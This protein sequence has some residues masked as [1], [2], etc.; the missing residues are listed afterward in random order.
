MSKV[1]IVPKGKT[2]LITKGKN[3][4]P[5]NPDVDLVLEENITISL[6]SSFAPL[7]APPATNLIT[8]AGKAI[9]DWTNGRVN[10][11]GQWKHLSY[12]TWQ[13][14][15]PISFNATI[16]LY[17]GAAGLNDGKTEVYDPAI[18]LC[19]LVLPT[20]GLGGNL[21][22]PGPSLNE[23]IG[24]LVT[25]STIAIEIGRVLRISHGIILKA[26]PQF[27]NETDS[28]G[29]PIWA[30]VNLDIN[31]IFSATVEALNEINTP[32]P[33]ELKPADLARGRG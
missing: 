33:Q 26:E 13:G 19:N 25:A 27:S 24:Q 22:A 31:S 28:N 7:V 8:E 11:S 2:L 16:G 29:Y 10:F 21:Q 23:V 4:V 17:M 12:Q 3:P 32:L 9:R 30:V 20:E 1:I 18:E 14:T 5:S 6:S 15:S